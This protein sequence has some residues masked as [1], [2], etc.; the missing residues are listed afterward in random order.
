MWVL[1]YSTD[2]Q[3]V[4]R[5][6]RERCK[7][8]FSLTLTYNSQGIERTTELANNIIATILGSISVKSVNPERKWNVTIEKKPIKYLVGLDLQKYCSATSSGKRK[9]KQ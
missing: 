8:R 5:K 7:L 6:I 4:I 1:K 3:L 9:K 2:S